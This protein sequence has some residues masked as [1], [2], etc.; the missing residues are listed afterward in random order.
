MSCDRE[1][2]LSRYIDNDLSA[3]ETSEIRRHLSSCRECQSAYHEMLQREK[4]LRDVL[5]PVI[6]AMTLREKVMRRITAEGIRPEIAEPLPNAAQSPRRSLHL[7]YALAFMLVAACGLLFYLTSSPTQQ[8]TRKVE[9]V[10]LM[11]LGDESRYGKRMLKMRDTCYAQPST[12]VPMRGEFAIF[13]NGTGA[14]PVLFSGSATMGIDF[15]SAAWYSGEGSFNTP[16]GLEFALHLGNDRI[17]MKDAELYISGTGGAYQARLSRGTASRVRG[18]VSEKLCIGT[19]PSPISTGTVSPVPEIQPDTAS[20]VRIE[21]HPASEPLQAAHSAGIATAG[22][23]A[24]AT[25]G[26]PS[27][28][29]TPVEVSQPARNPFGGGPVHNQGAE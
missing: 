14:P 28:Q 4:A 24:T 2:L 18:G 15:A 21:L 10:V 8:M 22:S 3:R 25:N 27:D 7:A 19:R 12:V 9:M 17:V 13:L 23:P 26:R 6:S 11:G 1:E 16:P 5:Q 20:A 29:T